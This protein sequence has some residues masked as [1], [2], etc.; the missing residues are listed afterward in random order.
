MPLTP[1]EVDTLHAE[2]GGGAHQR[3]FAHNDSHGPHYLYRPTSAEEL[4]REVEAYQDTDFSRVSIGRAEAAMSYI[5]P[6][7][8][9]AH[10][11]FLISQ[12]LPGLETDS[13]RK[14]GAAI[15]GLDSI[16]SQ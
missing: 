15:S 8:L 13:W 9:D 5:T 10:P 16:R 7:K 2:Q 1:T 3:L 4:R 11:I 12:S 6:P 14:A